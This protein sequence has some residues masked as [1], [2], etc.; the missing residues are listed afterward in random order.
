MSNE[1]Y[2]HIN[3]GGI[4]FKVDNRETGA[5]LAISAKHFGVQTAQMEIPVVSEDLDALGRFFKRASSERLHVHGY[6]PIER[7]DPEETG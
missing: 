6:N 7:H 5:V 4:S 2:F 3:N 1:V